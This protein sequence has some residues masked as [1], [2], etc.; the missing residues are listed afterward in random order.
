[1]PEEDGGGQEPHA[2]RIKTQGR[3]TELHWNGLELGWNQ[4]CDAWTPPKA[5]HESYFLTL[6]VKRLIKEA[7]N[8]G[9]DSCPTDTLIGSDLQM[10]GG[11]LLH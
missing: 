10:I 7:H 11:C 9:D 2:C 3:A 1:M 4:S 6:P 5:K 8:C